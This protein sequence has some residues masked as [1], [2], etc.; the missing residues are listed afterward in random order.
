MTTATLKVTDEQLYSVEV[1]AKLTAEAFE[2]QTILPN[3]A[4]YSAATKTTT[5]SDATI[6]AI[7]DRE[8]IYTVYQIHGK[9]S[10]PEATLLID[11]ETNQVI[12][13]RK[14]VMDEDEMEEMLQS[15]PELSSILRAL[16]Y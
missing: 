6:S 11:A 10:R 14:V 13:L 2:S 5:R 1:F 3:M 9:G 15:M 12:N 8:G 4:V 7:A 16:D